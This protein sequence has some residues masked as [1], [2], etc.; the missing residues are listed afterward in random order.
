MM[1]E[2]LYGKSPS[3]GAEQSCAALHPLSVAYPQQRTSSL[4]LSSVLT[5]PYLTAPGAFLN[6]PQHTFY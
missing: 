4:Q 6:P 3:T 1:P 5:S 2:I